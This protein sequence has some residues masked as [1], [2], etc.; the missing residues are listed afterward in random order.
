MSARGQPFSVLIP[1]N[2]VTPTQQTTAGRR[3]RSGFGSSYVPA[4]GVS[5][6][7]PGTGGV[8]SNA[9]SGQLTAEAA[10]RNPWKLAATLKG[11][12]VRASGALTAGNTVVI[13]IRINGVA[14]ALTVTLD[15]NSVAG[16]VYT[17]VSD[18][19]VAADDQVTFEMTYAGASGSNKSF[20]ATLEY[21]PA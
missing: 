5:T 12:Y 4:S 15:V 6:Y 10:T 14:T 3:K 13:T 16:T 7:L 8:Q 20:A 9:A 2:S 21:E 19:A 17:S 1:S 18:V 11:L